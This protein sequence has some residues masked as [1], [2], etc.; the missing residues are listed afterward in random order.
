MAKKQWQGAI[1]TVVWYNNPARVW[2]DGDV[3]SA[4][5]ERVSTA[6]SLALFPH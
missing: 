1:W 6:I 5:K 2:K 4:L 3:H